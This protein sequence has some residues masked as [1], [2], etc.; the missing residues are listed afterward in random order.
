MAE[1]KGVV[2][3]GICTGCGGCEAICPYR[4]VTVKEHPDADIKCVD[5]Y[6]IKKQGLDVPFNTSAIIGEECADCYACQR[7]C[8]ALSGFPKDEF[9]NVLKIFSAKSPIKGQD[10]GVVTKILESLLS[11]GLIDCALSVVRDKKWGTK[12]VVITESADVRKVAGTKYTAAPILS[13]LRDCIDEY[14]RIA[15]V[16]TPCQ[17]TA[18]AQMRSNPLGEENFVDPVALTLGL[19]CTWALDTRDLIAFLSKLLPVSQIRKMD[20]PPPPAEIMVLETQLG[21]VEVPL[22]DIRAL[23]PAACHVCPDMTSE[24]ADLSVGVLEGKPDWNTL[25]IRTEKGSQLVDA[26]RDEGYLVVDK[27]PEGNLTHLR[28]AAENKKKRSL[29]QAREKDILNSTKEGT[30]ASL[31]LRSEV[32]QR[33]IAQTTE[34]I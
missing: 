11:Q 22:D 27:I 2:N 4:A 12:P 13:L 31:R 24:W 18:V 28:S 23:V 20:I 26:A 10:G 19:F 7:I 33:I 1:I 8:P 6:L 34:E 3:A 29:T 32:V 25:I 21:K 9:D 5:C 17:L 15:V 30:R 14:E 16:G